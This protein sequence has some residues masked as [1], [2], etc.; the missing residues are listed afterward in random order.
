MEADDRTHVADTSDLSIVRSGRV[1]VR[2]RVPGL[3]R[4]SGTR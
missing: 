2:R 3:S 1:G 4:P